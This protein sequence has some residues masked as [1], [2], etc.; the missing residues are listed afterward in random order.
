MADFS[1]LFGGKRKSDFGAVRSVDDPLPSFWKMMESTRK[2][3]SPRQSSACIRL[4]KLQRVSIGPDYRQR[5]A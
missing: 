2:A 3:L 5:S 1:P 4:G